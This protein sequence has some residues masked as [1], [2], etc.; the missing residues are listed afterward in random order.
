MGDTYKG[1]DSAPAINMK[2]QSSVPPELGPQW[3]E[4]QRAQMQQQALRVLHSMQ[5]R[6]LLPVPEGWAQAGVKAQEP[7]ELYRQMLGL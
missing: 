1:K 3:S 2:K 6:G 5:R 7:V 4:E